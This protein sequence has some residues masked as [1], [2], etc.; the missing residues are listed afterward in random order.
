MKRFVLVLS[1]CV[2]PLAA[3][4]AK[5]ESREAKVERLLTLTGVDAQTD[6]MM[7]Q[8]YKMA[9]A[10]FPSDAPPEVRVKVEA[11]QAK[12][13]AVIRER[14]GWQ[15]MRPLYVKLYAE[16]YTDEDLDGMIAFF[17]SP[18]GRS[19]TAK[20]PVLMQRSMQLVQSVMTEL[21]PEIKR[22]AAEGAQR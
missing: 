15:K 5:P 3:Q 22:I 7:D 8:V 12:V 17:S 10:N 21:M 14:M 16:V 19:M 20:N 1:L 9:V 13:F 6:R 18:A 4:E 11:A 2:W